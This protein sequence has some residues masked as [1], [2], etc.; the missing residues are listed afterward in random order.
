MRQWYLRFQFMFDTPGDAGGGAGAGSTGTSGAAPVSPSPV[1]TPTGAAP[2]SPTPS[3][4]AAPTGAAPAGTG[5]PAPSTPGSPAVPRRF[6]YTEDRSSWVPPHRLNEITQQARQAALEARR[7]RAMLEA[8]TGVTLR[9]PENI[10][11]RI[12]DAREAFEQVFPGSGEFFTRALPRLMQLAQAMEQGNISP[13]MFQRLPDALSATD[14]QWR[15]HGRQVLNTVYSE[16]AKDYGVE[17]LSPYQQRVLGTAFTDWLS[18]DVQLQERYANNDPNLVKEFLTEYRSGF[19]DPLRRSA[20]A[21]TIARGRMTGALPA[22][23]RTGGAPPPPASP[24]PVG[25]EVHDRAWA[26]FA[27]ANQR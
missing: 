7:Y 24:A 13:E 9:Q 8:G 11:P 21:A 6:E 12:A 14:H 20:D 3:G 23:P 2:A 15:Q 1:A 17:S 10:D 19:V 22:V 4:A 18:Q 27:A 5:G 25:D 16:M 26:A